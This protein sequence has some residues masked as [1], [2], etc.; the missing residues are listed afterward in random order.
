MG[1]F[2]WASY[3]FL[4]HKLSIFSNVDTQELLIIQSIV[5][6]KEEIEKKIWDLFLCTCLQKHETN[7]NV[8]FLEENIIIL[9]TEMGSRGY[10][11]K[12]GMCE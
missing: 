11:L 2:E 7:R 1:V 6:S 8:I 12:K 9:C 5:N 4:R 3:I 10:N